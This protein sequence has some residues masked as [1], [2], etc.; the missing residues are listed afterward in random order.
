MK[1]AEI[2]EFDGEQV[3]KLPREYRFESDTVSIRKE[4][5][6]IVLEPLKPE[7][8]PVGFFDEIRIDDPAFARPD[9]GRMQAAP[10][11]SE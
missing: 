11:M 9:Q 1:T 5:E 7:S 2:I 8:W 4:G 10:L 6:E 3:V